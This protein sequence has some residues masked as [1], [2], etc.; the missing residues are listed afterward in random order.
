[1]MCLANRCMVSCAFHTGEGIGHCRDRETVRL[2][3]VLVHPQFAAD[4]VSAVTAH[5]AATLL[6]APPAPKPARKQQQPG[7]RKARQRAVRQMDTA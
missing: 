5:L 1:M 3:Q 6:P 4:P 2:Q 7:S